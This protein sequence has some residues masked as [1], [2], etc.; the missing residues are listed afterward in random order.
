MI[1]NLSI[2]LEYHNYF[3]IMSNSI[4]II[5]GVYEIIVILPENVHTVNVS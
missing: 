3:E 4:I 1:I 5:T 2:H